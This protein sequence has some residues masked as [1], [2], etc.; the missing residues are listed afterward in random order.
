MVT[1]TL[2]LMVMLAGIVFAQEPQQQPQQMNMNDYMA[3]AKE[4]LAV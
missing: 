3:L 4:D 1:R 2:M